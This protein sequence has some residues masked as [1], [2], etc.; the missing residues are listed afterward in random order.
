MG[1]SSYS[2]CIY[3]ATGMQEAVWWNGKWGFELGNGDRWEGESA[4]RDNQV[5]VFV[6][7]VVRRATM[8]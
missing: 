7:N 8:R 3:R 4:T 5:V 1:S 6:V 2:T